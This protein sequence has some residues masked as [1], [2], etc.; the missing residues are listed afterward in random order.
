MQQKNKKQFNKINFVLDKYKDKTYLTHNFHSF[1]AKFV[2]QIPK[3]VIEKFT[4]PKDLVLDPFCG[5]GTT[6]VEANLAGRDSIGLDT[7]PLAVL[8]SKCK[9]TILKNSDFL[10]IDIILEKIH[11]DFDE[12]QR[13]DNPKLCLIPDIYNVDLWFQK[14]V[15]SELGIIKKSVESVRDERQQNFMLTAFSAIVNPVSNQHSDTKYASVEKNI[16]TGQTVRMFTEKINKMKKRMEE[17]SSLATNASCM[18]SKS[19]ALSMKKISDSQID[20][21]VT[22]PPYAN[23]YDYYLYHKHRMNWLGYDIKTPQSVEIGSRN[24]HHDNN[25]P[26]TSYLES[27]KSYF[28]ECNRVL[29]TG[30]FFCIVVGDAIKDGNMISMDKEMKNLA[31]ETGFGLMQCFS[32]D[33][34]KYSFSFRWIGKAP[35]KKGHIMI[36]KKKKSI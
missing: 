34:R 29:R 14:N 24:K 12:F 11:N 3:T 36:F 19:S 31:N 23:T 13:T 2:P 8:I 17:F 4:K 18:V 5:S 32:Y 10:E 26:I 7:N 16:Q 20:F 22:S 33:L 28:S 15:Q 27:L 35:D 21:I 30:K 9:T 6:L 25:L 1:P